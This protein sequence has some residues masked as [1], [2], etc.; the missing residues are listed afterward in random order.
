MKEPI[1]NKRDKVIACIGNIRLNSIHKVVGCSYSYAYQVLGKIELLNKGKVDHVA[2]GKKPKP[3]KSM[4]SMDLP[5][6]Y[7]R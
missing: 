2:R 6:W 1:L 4:V 7:R 5:D 3:Y